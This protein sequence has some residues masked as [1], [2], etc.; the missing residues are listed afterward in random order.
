[1]DFR[2]IRN[3]K[4]LSMSFSYLK[5][6]HDVRALMLQVLPQLDPQTLLMFDEIVHSE[7]SYAILVLDNDKRW[8]DL[9]DAG[10][11]IQQQWY[12]HKTMYSLT[13]YGKAIYDFLQTDLEFGKPAIEDLLER[14]HKNQPGLVSKRSNN[15]TIDVIKRSVNDSMVHLAS[16][17]T[18]HQINFMLCITAHRNRE[19]KTFEEM[20]PPDDELE[21]LRQKRIVRKDWYVS[22]NG[23]RPDVLFTILGRHF[24]L[25]LEEQDNEDFNLHFKNQS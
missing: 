3:L 12:V 15:D 2:T 23:L 19:G 22:R 11:I 17:L 21:D 4:V 13:E 5:S 10:I 7:Y 16:Q 25:W 8:G 6:P 24:C 14:V 18:Q 20:L 9:K 1:M